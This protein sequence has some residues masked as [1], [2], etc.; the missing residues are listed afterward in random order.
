MTPFSRERHALDGC[1]L[2]PLE[3]A[4]CR[5]MAGRLAAIDPWVG[6]GY[7]A[8]ALARYLGRDDGALLRFAVEHGD[9]SRAGLLAVR[10]PWLRGPYIELLAIFPAHQGHGLGRVVVEWAAGQAAAGSAN[11][12]ACVSAFNASAR[13]FYA[14]RGFIEVAPLDDLVAPGQAELLL[15]RRLG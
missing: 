8:E 7:G 2:R 11:L 12:W 5:A 4:D 13:A 14:T 15:R 1:R 10:S 6:L 3:A 9:D